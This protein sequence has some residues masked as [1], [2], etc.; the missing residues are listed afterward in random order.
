MRLLCTFWV[1]FGTFVLTTHAFASSGG[2][3]NLNPIDF[4][5]ETAIWTLVIFVAVVLLLGKYAFGPIAKALDDREQ[6]ISDQIASANRA[7]EEA[8]QLLMQYNEKLDASKDEVRLILDTAR[9]DAQRISDGIIEKAKET[10]KIEQERAMKEIDAATTNALQSIAEKSA[11]MA[12][13]LAGKMIRAE[14]TPD[15][16]KNLIDVALS[17]VGQ[18]TM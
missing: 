11:I 18:K 12:T 5:A 1:L 8:K 13:T 15:K 4:K 10:A 2:D 9:K 17:Q 3:A 16:H 6:G 14:I 7:N